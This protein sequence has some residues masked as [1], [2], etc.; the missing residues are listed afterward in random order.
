VRQD[1]GLVGH[2]ALLILLVQPRDAERLLG[3]G[4]VEQQRAVF[5]AELTELS[6]YSERRAEG[7]C[8]AVSEGRGYLDPV[9]TLLRELQG[10]FAG[11]LPASGCDPARTVIVV[12]PFWRERGR[13]LGFGG[14]WT[15]AGRCTYHLSRN[16][17]GRLRARQRPCVLE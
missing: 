9:P 7:F 11:V 4:T 13:T 15:T 8:V 3:G 5:I 10:R 16:V 14:Q 6:S 12:G 2:A 17:F 1:R